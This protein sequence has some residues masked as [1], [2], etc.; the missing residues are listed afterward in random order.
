MKFILFFLVL[1]NCPAK[2]EKIAVM[3]GGSGENHRPSNFFTQD[4]VD[5][6][7]S[8]EARGWKVRVVFDSERDK[9]K[10]EA[11]TATN[12]NILAAVNDVT[13]SAKADDQVLFFVH[14][15][16]GKPESASSSTHRIS[17]E[18]NGGLQTQV[19]K[20]AAEGL[21]AKGIKTAFADLSCFSGSSQAA[22]AAYCTVSLASRDYVSVCAAEG[23]LSRFT[24]NFITFPDPKTPVNLEDH[25]FKA[26]SSDTTA[27]NVPQI[28]SLETPSIKLWD[29]FMSKLDPASMFVSVGPLEDETEA[30]ICDQACQEAT[31]DALIADLKKTAQGIQ[32]GALATEIGFIEKALKAFLSKRSKYV[33]SIAVGKDL[34]KQKVE[35]RI[36]QEQGKPDP[37]VANAIMSILT[38]GDVEGLLRFVKAYNFRDDP[39]IHPIKKAIY[40]SLKAY[41]TQLLDKYPKLAQAS[42]N[43]EMMSRLAGE[44]SELAQTVV[45][46]ERKYYDAFREL[47]PPKKG[48]VCQNFYF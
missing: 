1:F 34:Y 26:R 17:T 35:W 10:I 27:T 29:I 15:H 5:M 20:T 37:A 21:A 4:F 23:Q 19:F 42:K 32:G 31:R 8:L 45:A 40:S 3:I 11:P 12:S 25:F 2:A 41:E 38:V 28:S 36:T 22:D 39:A 18:T 47:Q 14:A 48:N 43:M 7:K 13:K 46:G 33:K 6:K 9:A 16:G 24:K 44:V 30:W